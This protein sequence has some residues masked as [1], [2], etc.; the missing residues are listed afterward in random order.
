MASLHVLI[1]GEEVCYFVEGVAAA[2]V[3]LA[4]CDF[5]LCLVEH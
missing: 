1:D 3:G 4:P 2:E 5:K